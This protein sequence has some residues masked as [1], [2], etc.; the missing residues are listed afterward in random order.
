MHIC[1]HVRV[2]L[3]IRIHVRKQ[4]ITHKNKWIHACKYTYLVCGCGCGCI[5]V[6][7]CISQHILSS[8]HRTMRRLTLNTH[9]N[10]DAVSSWPCQRRAAC[11]G[12]REAACRAQILVVRLPAGLLLR[13]PPFSWFPLAAYRLFFCGFARFL[14]NGWEFPHSSLVQKGEDPET[15]GPLIQGMTPGP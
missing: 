8:G 5:I 1:P 6:F 9:T 13:I 4:D 3:R 7:K 12:S 15:P 14:E 2:Y 11:G 10:R